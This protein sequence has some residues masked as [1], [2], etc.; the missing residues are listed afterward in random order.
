MAKTPVIDEDTIQEGVINWVLAQ[1]QRRPELK[2]LLLAYHIENERE[3]EKNDPL[4]WQKIAKREKKGLL[5]GAS[6][7]HMPN[8]LLYL[9]LKSKTGTVSNKQ[10]EFRARVAMTHDVFFPRSTF[11]AVKIIKERVNRFYEVGATARIRAILH[12]INNCSLT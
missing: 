5:A 2:D 10:K 12:D 8:L 6:D 9:E 3:F 4:K 7:I 1:Q 11:E